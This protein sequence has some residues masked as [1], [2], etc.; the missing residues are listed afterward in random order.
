MDISQENI[1]IFAAVKREAEIFYNNITSVYC[2][3]FKKNIIFN[4]KGFEHIKIKSLNQPRLISDQYLRLKFLKL[5]PEVL[6]LA[7]T[8][9]EFREVKKK[10]RIKLGTR[11]KSR[12]Q[13]IKYYGFVVIINNI[14][15][16]I[17]IKNINSGE[18]FFWSVIPFWKTKKDELTGEIKKVFHEG[19]LEIQ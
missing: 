11:W 14:R 18:L 12:E 15:I 6:E 8:L 5:V 17:V 19:D 13:I 9:Q 3:Y 16:K 7:N 2:P 4:Q 1:E 10:E